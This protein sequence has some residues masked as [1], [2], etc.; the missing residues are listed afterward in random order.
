MLIV[1]DWKA[2]LWTPILPNLRIDDAV[3]VRQGG[4]VGW[5]I[6]KDSPQLAAAIR[7]FDAT[8]AKN[9]GTY[10][11]RLTSRPRGVR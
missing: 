10:A 4:H 11:Y 3:F 2:K 9:Q 6:R 7:D 8:I 1:D 5:A